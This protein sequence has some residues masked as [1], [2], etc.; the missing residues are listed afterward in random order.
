MSSLAVSSHATSVPEQPR[1]HRACEASSGDM[2]RRTCDPRGTSVLARQGALHEIAGSRVIVPEPAATDVAS[3]VTDTPWTN[4]A[5][6]DRSWSIG[7]S[8]VGSVP[9]QSPDHCAKRA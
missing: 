1:V 8:Q 6:T 2:D 9:E 4:F 3:N 7:T 5:T